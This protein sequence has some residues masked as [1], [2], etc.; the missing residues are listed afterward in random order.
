MS[1]LGC[2]PHKPTLKSSPQS[3][4]T[5]PLHAKDRL[6]QLSWEAC[7]RFIAE[8]APADLSDWE[9]LTRPFRDA[10]VTALFFEGNEDEQ[11]IQGETPLSD[12]LSLV[13]KGLLIEVAR[14]ACRRFVRTFTVDELAKH[15]RRWIVHPAAFNRHARA[16]KHETNVVFPQLETLKSRVAKKYALCFDFKSFFHQ[17]AIP[18]CVGAYFAIASGERFFLPTT[19]PTGASQPPLFAELLLS[20]IAKAVVQQVEGVDYDAFID[21]LRLTSDNKAHLIAAQEKFVD[22]C[23]QLGITLNEDVSGYPSSTYDFLGITFDHEHLQVSLS[24]KTQA[25]I[26]ALRDKLHEMDNSTLP[27][28]WTCR[29]AL[30]AFGLLVWASWVIDLPRAPFYTVYKYIRR[31]C[32]NVPLDEPLTL[33]RCSLPIW[34]AWCTSLLGT[35][36]TTPAA[37][38]QPQWILFTDSTLTG[39]GAIA[40]DLTG[41]HQER[42][43]AGRHD[44]HNASINYLELLTVR[45]SLTQLQ[46]HGAV[47]LRVDNTSALAA[48]GNTYSKNFV[49]NSELINLQKKLLQLGTRIVD[50]AYVNT[51]SNPADWFSRLYQN[52]HS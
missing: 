36:K 19:I 51:A 6:S 35:L 48:V 50:A 44:V 49:L 23:K 7:D 3:I 22:T 30:G 46:L 17:F 34:H 1:G 45:L 5:L 37:I 24:C 13:Q 2:W 26:A 47:A 12:L 9:L 14:N 16:C 42:I 52:P 40:F 27:T 29:D 25:K 39:Y 33:W 31:K 32:Q 21:N 18:P 8:W 28:T 38:V 20:A 4:S 41:T 10:S 43:V 15:R 11:P